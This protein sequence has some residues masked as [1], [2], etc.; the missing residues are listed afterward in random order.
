MAGLQLSPVRDGI[1]IAAI[2]ADQGSTFAIERANQTTGDTKRRNAALNF[3]ADGL[4]NMRLYPQAAELLTAG[5]EG[6]G[7]SSATLR[8]IQILRTLKPFHGDLLP[9]SDPRNPAQR[10]LMVTLTGGATEA[11]LSAIISKHAYADQGEWAAFMR[12]ANEE[13]GVLQQ[14]SIKTGLPLVMMRDIVLGTTKIIVE[15][16]DQP[17]YRIAIQTMIGTVRLFV[18]NEAGVFKIVATNRDTAAAG[19]EALYLL[20]NGQETAAQSLL[21]WKR[22]Q[23]QKSGDDDPLNDVPFAQLWIPGKS[24]GP[25][26]IKTA[27]A[28][29]LMDSAE[30]PALLPYLLSKRNQLPKGQYRSSVE[31][32]LAHI[33]LHMG[34]GHKATSITRDLL[35]EYPTS[36]TAIRLA[37][38]ADSLIRDWP[39]W[40]LMLESRLPKQPNDRFFLV[41][42]AEEAVAEGDF[43]R[44]R[45]RLRAVLDSGHALADDYNLYAWLR[46]YP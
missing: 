1:L 26:A 3:A 8:K 46:T 43:A 10:H 6:Q 45:K 19:S 33:Y 11:V 36:A 30:G 38:R 25:D 35:S 40:A 28:S 7:D 39:A 41:Q 37:G 44:A 13:T 34:D 42:M 4:T 21:N 15:P 17:G 20:H 14:L 18:V 31:V 27:A 2:A 29:L 23:I 9:D 22:D 32:M 12:K 16:S 24:K 5:I